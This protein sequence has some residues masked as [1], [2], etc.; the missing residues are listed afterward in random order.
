MTSFDLNLKFK[1]NIDYLGE[2]GENFINFFQDFNE[3]EKQNFN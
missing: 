3:E 2:K 1:L